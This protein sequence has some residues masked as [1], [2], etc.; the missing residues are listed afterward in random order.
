MR[1]QFGEDLTEDGDGVEV[2]GDDAREPC[3]EHDRAGEKN[4]LD[5]SRCQCGTSRS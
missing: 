2:E 3:E 1:R 5:Q 4:R